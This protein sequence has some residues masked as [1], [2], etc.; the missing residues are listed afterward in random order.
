MESGRQTHERTH[1]CRSLNKHDRVSNLPPPPDVN[2][3]CRGGSQSDHRLGQENT[4]FRSF[5][6]QTALS[7]PPYLCTEEWG[8]SRGDS[9]SPAFRTPQLQ[10]NVRLQQ[11]R[12]SDM[13]EGTHTQEEGETNTLNK[14]T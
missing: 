1:S 7:L 10:R 11:L 12:P 13:D 4:K 9:L 2:Q 5:F 14:F 6:C 3:S 8:S